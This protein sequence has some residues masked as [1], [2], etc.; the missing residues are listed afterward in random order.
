MT[1]ETGAAARPEDV[2]AA[3]ARATGT[4][5][6]GYILLVLTLIYVVNYLDRQILGILLPYIQKEFVLT[7]FEGGLLS[8]TVFAVIY[9]T[10]GIPLATLADRWSR[11]N[12][13]AASL[14]TFSLMTVL[15][16]YVSQFWQLLATR[17]C[18]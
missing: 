15:S 11:R 17:F 12:I 14:A 1:I 16:G 4:S 3:T 10:L 5:H 9:A 8:G 7:D 13:I 6:R 18:T 2:V